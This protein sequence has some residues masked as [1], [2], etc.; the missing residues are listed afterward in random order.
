M[1]A[2]SHGKCSDQYLIDAIRSHNLFMRFILS[3]GNILFPLIADRS[4][5]CG[6]KLCC[7][8]RAPPV[9]SCG[10]LGQYPL[11]SILSSFLAAPPSS[12]TELSPR[13]N[14]LFAM[15]LKAMSSE[16]KCKISCNWE[17]SWVTKE[18]LTDLAAKGFLPPKESNVWRAPGNEIKPLPKSK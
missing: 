10:R 9:I 7:W 16:D 5:F 4:S 11:A 13:S 17:G 3:S 15:A 18:V 12:S 8:F 6:C 14:L 1:V 2:E